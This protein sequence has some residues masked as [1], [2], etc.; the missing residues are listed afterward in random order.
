MPV[1]P[2]AAGIETAQELKTEA[3]LFAHQ[4]ALDSLKPVLDAAVTPKDWIGGSH[5][6]RQSQNKKSASRK[7]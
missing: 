5:G 2:I 3:I 4:R 7:A 1:A 6:K